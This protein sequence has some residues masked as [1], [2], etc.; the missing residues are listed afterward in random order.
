MRNW[1]AGF[2]LLTFTACGYQVGDNG[3][4]SSYKTVSVPYIQG[5]VTGA[6]TTAVIDEISSLGSTAYVLS[7]ADLEL[8]M[9]VKESRSENT[10]YQFPKDVSEDNRLVASQKREEMLLS[11]ELVDTRTGEALFPTHYLTAGTEYSFLPIGRAEEN[12]LQFSLGQLDSQEGAMD[13]SSLN[14]NQ[15]M[16]QKVVEYLYSLPKPKI[17]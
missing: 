14:L 11:I 12:I 7:S 5:D 15:Q 10:G 8:K 4:L 2:I 1:L 16:A 13:F 3:L 9:E 17:K 6:L